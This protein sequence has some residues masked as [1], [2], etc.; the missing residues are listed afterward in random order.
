M[1]RYWKH[2]DVNEYSFSAEVCADYEFEAIAKDGKTFEILE[3]RENIETKFLA[4]AVK[5]PDIEE[6]KWDTLI[7][8]TQIDL[9]DY[10]SILRCRN[11]KGAVWIS[12]FLNHM[13][14][15]NT[16]W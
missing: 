7:N 14:F 13:C 4:S 10:K 2:I 9:S 5:C 11:D 8:A 3:E 6:P 16:L 1:E 15:Q 12:F